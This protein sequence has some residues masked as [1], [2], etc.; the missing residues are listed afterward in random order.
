MSRF[1]LVGH[2]IASVIIITRQQQQKIQ[3]REMRVHLSPG[4]A[5]HDDESKTITA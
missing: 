4:A 2:I 1:L 5:A 3:T